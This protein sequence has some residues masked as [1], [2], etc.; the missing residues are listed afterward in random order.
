MQLPLKCP[1]FH[2]RNVLIPLLLFLVTQQGFDMIV[3][4]HKKWNFFESLMNKTL[5]IKIN[6]MEIPKFWWRT[7]SQWL[8][9]TVLH[10]AAMIVIVPSCYWLFL[11]PI[12]V[13][14]ISK[15]RTQTLTVHP[16]WHC[17]FLNLHQTT[18][19]PHTAH[20]C[21]SA[22]YSSMDVFTFSYLPSSQQIKN[23]L[24]YDTLPPHAVSHVA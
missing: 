14:L 3:F 8:T 10:V 17:L 11:A 4:L 12:F 23:H 16:A 13:P 24:L 6:V 20:F 21:L 22:Q 5:F 15:I 1:H 7:D 9:P 2:L 19:P 18:R